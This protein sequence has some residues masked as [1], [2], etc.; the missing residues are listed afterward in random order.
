VSVLVNCALVV[1]F[2]HTDVKKDAR[3]TIVYAAVAYVTSKN[4]MHTFGLK[5]PFNIENEEM[6]KQQT[7]ADIVFAGLEGGIEKEKMQREKRSCTIATIILNVTECLFIIAAAVIFQVLF[8]EGNDPKQIV[9]NWSSA[10]NTQNRKKLVEVLT[11]IGCVLALI[12]YFLSSLSKKVLC[13]CIPCANISMPPFVNQ[14]GILIA[15]ATAVALAT[16]IVMN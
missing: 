7:H 12:I 14:I 4:Y 9:V 15:Q 10:N 5:R 3:L 6:V 16:V 8:I 11:Y 2:T 1:I 13:R